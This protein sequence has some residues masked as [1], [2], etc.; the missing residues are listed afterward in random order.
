MYQELFSFEENKRISN[1][2]L[3]T[4]E[5]LSDV[6]LMSV[7]ACV[8]CLSGGRDEQEGLAAVGRICEE[9]KEAKGNMLENT[10]TH[11]HTHTHVHVCVVVL[12]ASVR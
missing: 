1:I 9:Y 6:V 3:K 5:G 4:F 10:H 8:T 2:L 7:C 12:Y 11:T